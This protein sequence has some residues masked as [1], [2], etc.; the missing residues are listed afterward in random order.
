MIT[1]F[2]GKSK[3]IT[4]FERV[5][6]CLYLYS[7]AG[8]LKIVFVTEKIVRIIYTTGNEFSKNEKPGVIYDSCISD[9]NYF[10]VDSYIIAGTESLSVRIL[11]KTGALSYFDK[12]KG[13]LFKENETN[14][15]EFENF[16]TFILTDGEQKTK[17]IQTADGEKQVIIDPEKLASGKSNHIRI[18]MNFENEALYGMGQQEKGFASLLG[19]KLYLHQANRKIAVPFF[20]STKGYG[21]LVN[22]YSP[23]IFTDNEFESSIFI[24]AAPELDYY[25]IAGSMNEVTG[26]YRLLTGKAAMLPKWA[27]GY[28]QSQER[29]ETADEIIATVD[30]SR[31]LGLGM[32]CIVLDWLSWGENLWGQKSFDKTRFPDPKKMID[33][34]HKKNV[35]FM[36]SIWPTC[37]DATDDNKEF[38]A[39]NG[40][41]PASTAFNAFSKESRDLYWKQLER[42]HFVSG[43]DAWWC[44][45][46]EPFTPEWNHII[47]PDDAANYAEYLSEAGLRMPYAYSNS[48]ALYHAMGIYENQ[49]TAMKKL[50]EENPAYSEKRVCN[51]T[52]SAYIGQQRYGTIMWSGDTDASWSTLRDQVSIGLHFSASGIPFW[53]VDVGAFFVKKGLNWYWNGHFDDTVDNPGYAELYTRWYQYACFLPVFR[54]HGTDCRRELWNFTGKFYDALE[55]TNK[56]RYELMPYIYSEAGKVWLKD[57]SLIRWLAFDFTEDEKVWNITDQYLFGES[58]MV[59]PVLK[60]MY[61]NEAGERID[62]D[63][64]EDYYTREV[65]LPKNCDWYDYYTGERFEGGSTVKALATL[66]RIPVFVRAGSIIPTAQP[67]LSTAE[68]TGEINLKV[69]SD[70]ECSYEFYED[71]GDGYGYEKGEYTLK[72]ITMKA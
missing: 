39:I 11:K 26:G 35:H 51:L 42:E 22:A 21:F 47:R 10:E 58:L 12:E 24:E 8:I 63:V 19:H 18:N 4:R 56:L 64:A 25:F 70:G 72:T 49:R 36:I 62:N 41:L 43:V 34:L 66:D 60:P 3:L 52:R 46:S 53:T 15:R 6:D 69:F 57:R 5:N 54:C 55:R 27:Y 29:Y 1:A 59:C 13:L 65:Y 45:S 9:W 14:P 67:A 50:S 23:M 71:S 16:D 32:D 7:E 68:Q 28:I 37:A 30:K 44:D 38:K 33:E 20:V 17:I 40:L 48:Y 2:P 31:E 61:Y